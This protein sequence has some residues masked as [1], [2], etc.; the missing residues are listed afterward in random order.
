MDRF[1]PNLIAVLTLSLLTQ[2]ECTKF[3][4]VNKCR[5]TIWPGTL[6]GSGTSPLSTTG[7]SLKPSKSKTLTIPKS[8]SGRLWART[9]CITNSTTH[10]FTCA[11]ADCGSGQVSCAGAGA[12]PPATL[13]E[14]TLNGDKNL[15]FY[16]VSLVDGYNL[17]VLIVPRG[18]IGGGCAATGCLV[19]L[20]SACP[21]ELRV[22]DGMA[23]KSACEA[24]G[25][26]QYCCSGS[27]STPETCSP[28][29]FSLYFKHACPR[30]Y[31]YAYDDKTS[32][33]TCEGAD[34]LIIFCPSPYTSQK[35]LGARREAAE[36]PL[37]N[38]TMMYLGSQHSSYAVS[39][40]TISTD[41]RLS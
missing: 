24:F 34:Y 40:A 20:N 12:N 38:K 29:A 22:G 7:F 18:G 4:I 2:T 28:S 8:W 15:D 17:P 5:H 23:C 21:N 11:T 1:I 3:K 14:F 27:Y 41:I 37:V 39:T 25:E 10:Q 6:S 16:D 30:A 26:D 33:Y 9:H 35:L 31:S 13:V 32:T 19:D 36:L